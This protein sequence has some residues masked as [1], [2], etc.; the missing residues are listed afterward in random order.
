ML[1]GPRARV[2]VIQTDVHS[3]TGWIQLGCVSFGENESL[4]REE[5]NVFLD[6]EKVLG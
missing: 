1:D 3:H 4:S 2:S 5:E 6:E